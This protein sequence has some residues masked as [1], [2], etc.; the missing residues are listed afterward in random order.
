M[1]EHCLGIKRKDLRYVST[2]SN[3]KLFV[4]LMS[5]DG[6]YSEVFLDS[7]LSHSNGKRNVQQ[8]YNRSA[9]IPSHT[10]KVFELWWQILR[11]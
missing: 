5:V 9:I 11:G 4:T 10:R 2:H 8:I 6:T 3:R 1:L 7:L